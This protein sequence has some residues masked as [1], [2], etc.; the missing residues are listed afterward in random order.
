MTAMWNFQA[1]THERTISFGQADRFRY[2]AQ[3]HGLQRGQ[4]VT[5]EVFRIRRWRIHAP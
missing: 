4:N 3:Q 5:R 1:A 2:E